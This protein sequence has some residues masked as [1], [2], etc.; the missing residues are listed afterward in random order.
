MSE[1]LYIWACESCKTWTLCTLPPEAIR[2]AVCST[3]KGW[4]TVLSGENAEDVRDSS[5]WKKSSPS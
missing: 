4:L 1:P 2:G 5:S 3:C